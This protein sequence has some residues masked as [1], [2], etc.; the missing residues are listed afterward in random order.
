[1]KE[2]DEA[3]Q[4]LLET[5]KEEVYGSGLAWKRACNRTISPILKQIDVES[6]KYTETQADYELCPLGARFEHAMGAAGYIGSSIAQSVIRYE[7]H[8]L[9]VTGLL[10][11]AGDFEEMLKLAEAAQHPQWVIEWALDQMRW[12]IAG[13]KESAQL[14]QNLEDGVLSP[15]QGLENCASRPLDSYLNHLEACLDQVEEGQRVELRSKI[16]S[17]LEHA[18]LDGHIPA[19]RERLKQFVA[20]LQELILQAHD[21]GS[22]AEALDYGLRF[23]KPSEALPRTRVI[24]LCAEQM[25]TLDALDMNQIYQIMTQRGIDKRT[26]RELDRQIQANQI[27]SIIDSQTPRKLPVLKAGTSSVEILWGNEKGQPREI[28]LTAD[29]QLYENLQ[30]PGVPRPGSVLLLSDLD[31]E[32]LKKNIHR[33]AFG[34]EHMQLPDG[35]HV[36][37]KIPADLF[38]I[39]DWNP[40]NLRIESLVGTYAPCDDTANCSTVKVLREQDTAVISMTPLTKIRIDLPKKEDIARPS[41]HCLAREGGRKLPMFSTGN[42]FGNFHAPTEEEKSRVGKMI[43]AL[44][45][46]GVKAYT[47]NFQQHAIVFYQD[48]KGAELTAHSFA[49][50]LQGEKGAAIKAA[51]KLGSKDDFDVDAWAEA[52][53]EGFLGS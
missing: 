44:R 46:A 48:R 17:Y 18:K 53:V 30:L 45:S 28:T 5:M 37:W 12:N 24:A 39:E 15:D 9:K 21:Y 27:Q 42:T 49:E 47:A 22:M 29:I 43:Q 26:I 14:L 33:A 7:Q 25:M 40:E 35:R 36:V 32:V 11:K 16:L 2:Y 20:T 31:F 51:I 34:A 6:E 1:M 10:E 19:D 3:N 8:Y 52:Y 4:K 50:M 13:S 23:G 41:I 38:R